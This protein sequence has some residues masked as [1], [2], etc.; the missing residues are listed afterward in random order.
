VTRWP[1]ASSRKR[2][3]SAGSWTRATR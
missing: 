2:P 3:T 1:T